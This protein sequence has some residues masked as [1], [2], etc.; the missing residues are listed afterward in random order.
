[1]LLEIW[2]L[3]L[4]IIAVIGRSV[5][6]IGVTNIML[7]LVLA[8]SDRRPNSIDILIIN[9]GL[10]VMM[11][12]LMWRS[13]DMGYEYYSPLLKDLWNSDDK[14]LDAVLITIG[15][16]IGTKIIDWVMQIFCQKEIDRAFDD[17]ILTDDREDL[18][19]L[20]KNRDLC[21]ELLN[22]GLYISIIGTVIR[23]YVL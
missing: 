8:L 17:N 14:L 9:T 19:Q 16:S 18:I 1:M 20:Y 12:V 22:H 2:K 11:I 7:L 5:I 15:V 23:D 4:Q 6:Y 3:L 13:L 21:V 10:M